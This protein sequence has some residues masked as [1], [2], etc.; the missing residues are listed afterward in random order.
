VTTLAAFLAPSYADLSLDVP[1]SPVIPGIR[2]YLGTAAADDPTTLTW[3]VTAVEWCN[4]KLSRRD[5]VAAD[6]F[7]GDIPPHGA[8]VATYEFV[9][10]LN[11]YAARASVV[12]RK[13]KTGA[14]EEEYDTPGT[15]DRLSA[16][17]I[18]AWPY[19]EPFCE[20]PTLFASGGA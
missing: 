4:E 12:A 8:V 19:L 7:T 13:I 3:W 20:D 1:T 5:F 14:R 17:A 2:P 16:A 11:D 9:R 6:G 18:A 10:V 15:A